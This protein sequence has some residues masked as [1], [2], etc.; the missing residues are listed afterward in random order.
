MWARFFFAQHQQS[1]RDVI[2]EHPHTFVHVVN[3]QS[4][5][6]MQVHVSRD[7]LDSMSVWWQ[8]YKWAS[9]ELSKHLSLSLSIYLLSLFQ[10]VLTSLIM[11]STFS[12]FYPFIL[13]YCLSMSPTIKC[14][15][16]ACTSRSQFALWFGEYNIKH[17]TTTHYA[18][19]TPSLGS[20]F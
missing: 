11:F 15:V 17:Q 8:Y 19:L 9:T 18:P 10:S 6:S 7:G 2:S 20:K 4:D 14:F 16:S 3:D 5:L 13:S 1:H 12:F